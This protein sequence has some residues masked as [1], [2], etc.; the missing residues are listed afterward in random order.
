MGGGLVILRIDGPVPRKN[1]HW[2]IVSA[3]RQGGRPMMA[4]TAEGRDFRKRLAGV[5]RASKHWP[6]KG[7]LA[8]RITARWG[9]VRHMDDADY[10]MGDVDGPIFPVLDALQAAGVFEDDVRVMNVCATKRYAKNNPGI[11][12]M[13]ESMDYDKD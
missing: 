5:W 7:P 11:D 10:P 13:I 6:I 12:V 4:L 2:K 8:I 1:D 9:R 3:G